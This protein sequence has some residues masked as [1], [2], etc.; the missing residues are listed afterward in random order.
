MCH[1]EVDPNDSGLCPHCGE[2]L[3]SLIKVVV[4]EKLNLKASVN[5]TKISRSV[6]IKKTPYKIY[7]AIGLFIVGIVIGLIE[8]P[9]SFPLGII[10]GI[11][12]VA[13]TP[14]NEKIIVEKREH[15]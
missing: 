1:G 14:I 11:N 15:H 7:M 8:H 3:K 10:S 5:I 6:Q 4:N 13:L 12:G 9:L 2:P